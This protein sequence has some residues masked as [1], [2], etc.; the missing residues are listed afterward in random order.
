MY[1]KAVGWTV[2]VTG[3]ADVLVAKICT[4]LPTPRCR[5]LDLSISIRV[6]GKGNEGIPS[7]LKGPLA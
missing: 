5:I 4:V 2:T 3:N 6:E 7:K 1:T